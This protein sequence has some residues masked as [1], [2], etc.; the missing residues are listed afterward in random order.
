MSDHEP[1]AVRCLA[2]ALG[3][4]WWV[5]EVTV[6][7]AESITVR[8]SDRPDLRAVYDAVER[9]GEGEGTVTVDG[10]SASWAVEHGDGA[11]RDVHRVGGRYTVRRLSSPERLFVGVT[12]FGTYV[13]LAAVV[14][15]AAGFFLTTPLALLDVGTVAGVAGMLGVGILCVVVGAVAFAVAPGATDGERAGDP[16][17]DVAGFEALSPADR[18]A[19]VAADDAKSE[20]DPSALL[21]SQP[22][23]GV[24]GRF[25]FVAYLG[26]VGWLTAGAVGVLVAGGLFALWTVLRLRGT[27]A[28]LA[29]LD[30]LDDEYVNELVAEIRDAAGAETTPTIYG[31]GDADGP[32]HG[33]AAT[34]LPEL[35]AILVP[36]ADVEKLHRDEL[37][38]ILA[39]EYEHVRSHYPL[40]L[41]LLRAALVLLP[42]VVLLATGATPSALAVGGGLFGYLALVD[43]V[44]AVV[45]RRWEYRADA[46][47]G[48]VVSPLA[49]AFA[50]TRVAD[51]HVVD[52]D[53]ASILS[54]PTGELYGSHPYPH[55]RLAR[56]LRAAR[57]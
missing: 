10:P 38:A 1:S 12:L 5:D 41:A 54:W 19:L 48:E 44:L 35:N 46:F 43:A 17:G 45:R 26:V 34:A 30:P 25:G 56:L 4:L 40:V 52:A 47:A 14:T 37:Q 23:L 42:G 33:D 20:R 50:L 15:A 28:V 55:R 13:V 18:A 3:D 29:A 24:V 22:A 27:L 39:H 31:F 49:L 21:R 57:E 53:A 51:R 8:S 11:V 36:M 32:V 7:D 16:G 9:L 6:D 2:A